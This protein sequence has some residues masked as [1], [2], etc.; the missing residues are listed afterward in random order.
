MSAVPWLIHV[1]F[2]RLIAM[3]QTTCMIASGLGQL[4]DVDYTFGLIME[5]T[6][7]LKS[8]IMGYANVFHKNVFINTPHRIKM[9]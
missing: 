6:K 7:W 4:Y 1:C 2:Q 3:E 8:C 9:G 5:T